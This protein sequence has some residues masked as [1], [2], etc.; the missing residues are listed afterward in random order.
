MRGSVSGVMQGFA[1]DFNIVEG[2][3]TFAR[4]LMLLVA[5]A[6]DKDDVT[7]LGL[8]DGQLDCFQA[9]RL[10][11]VACPGALQSR[12]G[13]VH[14]GDGIFAARIVT[15][16]DHEVAS[17]SRRLAHQGP[18]GAVTITAASEDG[19]HAPRSATLAQKVMRHCGEIADGIVSVC[20]VNDHGERLPKIEPLKAAGDLSD[21]IR[22]FGDGTGPYVPRISSSG[23]GHKVV[24]VDPSQQRAPDGNLTLRRDHLETDSIMADLQVLGVEVAMIDAVSNHLVVV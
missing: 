5:L 23:G 2:K 10:Q 17:L 19:N 15:G 16:Q 7:G 9:V 13:V 12:Q 11:R 8:V 24:Y 20:V 22:S 1:G 6:G 4:H 21:L 18:L 14:D 3:H